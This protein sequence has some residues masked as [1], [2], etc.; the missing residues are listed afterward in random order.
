M[1]DTPQT[2]LAVGYGFGSRILVINFHLKR[3]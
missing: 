3:Q 1:S 2:K